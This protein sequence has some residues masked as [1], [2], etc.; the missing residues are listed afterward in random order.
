M[1]KLGMRSKGGSHALEER[2][3]DGAV[4]E[5]IYEIN[6]DDWSRVRSDAR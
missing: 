3:S 1:T 6:R 4:D 2:G 5:V